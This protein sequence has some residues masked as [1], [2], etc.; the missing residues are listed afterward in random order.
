MVREC[1][2]VRLSSRWLADRGPTL[3]FSFAALHDMVNNRE[4]GLVRGK[5]TMLSDVSTRT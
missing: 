5:C 2:E 1:N 4:R 3:V